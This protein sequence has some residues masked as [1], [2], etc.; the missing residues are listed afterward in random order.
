MTRTISALASADVRLPTSPSSAFVVSGCTT[1]QPPASFFT[2]ASPP[3]ACALRQSL[4][5][6]SRRGALDLADLSGLEARERLVLLLP[7]VGTRFGLLPGAEVDVRAEARE[8]DDQR[9]G[10]LQAAHLP[11]PPPGV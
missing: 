10:R 8:H 11:P 4:R 7:G 9:D 1:C 2:V 3:A 6:A 5:V